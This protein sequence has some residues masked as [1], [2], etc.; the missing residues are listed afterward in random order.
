MKVKMYKKQ[1]IKH[2]LFLTNH[3]W[4]EVFGFLVLISILLFMTGCISVNVNKNHP[5][6]KYQESL[7]RHEPRQ[8]IAYKDPNRPL[9]LLEPVPSKESTQPEIEITTDPGT[10]GKIVN[11]T[12]DDVVQKALANSPEIRVVSFDPSISRLDITKA[13]SEFDITSG[14]EP[15]P[16][17]PCVS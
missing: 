17:L 8:G 7:T 13:A 2:N 9:E 10:G 4:S 12:L 15:M 14:T 5:L 16:R 1:N 3:R 11:L 6:V